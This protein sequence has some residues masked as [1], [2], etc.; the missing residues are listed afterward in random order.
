MFF[1][2]ELRNPEVK[3]L[4]SR[5]RV[6]SLLDENIRRFQIAVNQSQVM[7]RADGCGRLQHDRDRAR[8]IKRSFTRQQLAQRVAFQQLH[9]DVEITIGRRSEVGHGYGVRML[10]AAGRARLAMKTML[11]GFVAQKS[12]A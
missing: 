1:N 5:R 4:H 9:H 7:R 6:R 3:H 8:R 10:H 2:N 11:G 12:L